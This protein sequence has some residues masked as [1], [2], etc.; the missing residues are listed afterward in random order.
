M[1]DKTI[2]FQCKNNT[3]GSKHKEENWSRNNIDGLC[4]KGCFVLR[5]VHLFQ[6]SFLIHCNDRKKSGEKLPVFPGP[7]IQVKSGLAG[8]AW[9]SSWNPECTLFASNLYQIPST[10]VPSH[11]KVHFWVFWTLLTDP[12]DSPPTQIWPDGQNFRGHMPMLTSQRSLTHHWLILT[13]HQIL[14]VDPDVQSPDR[15]WMFQWFCFS[16]Y[17]SVLRLFM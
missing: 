16:W 15:H 8:F 4:K 14:S 6:S 12:I 7:N 10:T 17:Y 2:T 13:R 9:L 5:A 11:Q 1:Y 3:N